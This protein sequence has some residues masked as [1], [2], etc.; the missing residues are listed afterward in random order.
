MPCPKCSPFA[1][2]FVLRGHCKVRWRGKSFDGD[3]ALGNVGLALM[4]ALG[5]PAS[6]F[7][8]FSK[9]VKVTPFREATPPAQTTGGL[10]Q[11]A[12]QT[13]EGEWWEFHVAV[14]D[15]VEP[16]LVARMKEAGRRALDRS[17]NFELAAVV[18]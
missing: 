4:Q 5:Y 2:H 15:E 9:R 3:Q 18:E 6:G 10:T 11:V 8:E 12:P 17:R 7:L 13:G 14:K 1:E 16:A